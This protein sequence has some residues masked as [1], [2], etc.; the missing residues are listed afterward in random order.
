MSSYQY[1]TINIY[2]Y[3]DMSV[4]QDFDSQFANVLIYKYEN[5]LIYEYIK[6]QYVNISMFSYM[7]E[8]QLITLI[9]SLYNN[10]LY[11]PER[12]GQIFGCCLF[13]LL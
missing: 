5:M 6:Y 13:Q 4:W 9:V 12:I 11:L 10:H 7:Q 2:Q 1:V 8:G 3:S